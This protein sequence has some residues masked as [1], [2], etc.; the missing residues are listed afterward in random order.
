MVFFSLPPFS[1]GRRRPTLC[2]SQPRFQPPLTTIHQP[3]T[4]HHLDDS[5]RFVFFKSIPWFPKF[6][7]S[8]APFMFFISSTLSIVFFFFTPPSFPGPA[9]ADLVLSAAAVLTAGLRALSF[10]C[11]FLFTPAVFPG[12]AQVDLVFFAGIDFPS[13]WVNA[14]RPCAFRRY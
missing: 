6:F 7:V 14:G 2:S 12:S 8:F 13:H 1:L 3:P 5:F 9:Q 11:G 4:A 10:P